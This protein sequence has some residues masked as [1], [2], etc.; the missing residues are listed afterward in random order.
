MSAPRPINLPSLRREHASEWPT[1]GNGQGS[2]TT[3]S[4][5]TTTNTT[6][7]NT[8]GIGSGSGGSASETKGWGSS[9]SLSKFSSPQKWDDTTTNKH[10]DATEW[11][12]TSDNN[13]SEL[14][15]SSSPIPKISSPVPASSSSPN[16]SPH[17]PAAAS[18]AWAAVSTSSTP[19]VAA[20]FPTA[21]E[22]N[23]A[24]TQES[25]SSVPIFIQ[26]VK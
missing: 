24:P 4:S 23:T 20:E 16:N 13:N 6:N 22:T 5:S 15:S 19:A 12:T 11:P 17:P 2:N 25:K 26:K 10:V 14:Q 8:T 9:P 3:S 18:R 7:A 1:S 21:A